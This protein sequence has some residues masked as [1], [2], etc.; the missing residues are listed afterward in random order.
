MLEWSIL[1]GVLSLVVCYSLTGI[2]IPRLKRADI[3]GEDENKPDKPRIPE[4]GGF[5][6][7]AGFTVG[8]LA[9]IFT[10]TFF[11]VDINLVHVLAVLVTV[12]MVAFIGVVD[13]LLSVPQW[14]KAFLPLGAAIPLIAVSAVGST[15]M[16]IPFIGEIDLG[17]F[18]I[19]VLVPIGVAVASNLTN[20]FAGYNGMEAGMGSIIFAAM[21]LIGLYNESYE[22]AAIAIAMLGALLGF[23]PFNLFPAKIFP[24]DVGNLSIGAALAASVIIGNFESAGAILM[25]PYVIDFFIK[26]KNKLPHTFCEIRDGKL[27]P[28]D[29]KIRG[30]VHV[31]MKLFNG[32]SE[33]D[34]TIFFIAV[35]GIFAILLF[36]L[37]LK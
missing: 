1:F 23:L 28:K 19:L 2:I 31:A 10:S 5:A 29:G 15:V 21:F 22:M 25:I 14:L 33:R 11:S 8:I 7:V 35:E 26:L 4:M 16:G 13:D 17:I 12:H 37:Y 9:A 30:F 32:I 6:I 3:T 20:M 34:L 36:L 18:Y 24:G 27:Y